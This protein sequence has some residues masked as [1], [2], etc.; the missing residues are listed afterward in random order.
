MINFQTSPDRY[1][2]WKL[3]VDGAVATLTMDV[4][5]DETLGEGYK[6][7]L[8]SYDLGVDIEL[9]DA[10][11]RIRFEHPEVR[12]VVVT[13]LKPRIFCAGAN[14]YMLGTSSHAFKVNF[15]KFTNETRCAME[16]DSQHSGRRYLAA[17]NGTASGGGYELAIAC[18]EI[19]LVDDGN[20]AVSLP[21]VPLLGVL[22]GTGGLTRLVD[23][24]KVRRDRADVFSTLA[25]GLKGKRAKEWGLID[26]TFPTS[27]FQ[28]SIE[29]RVAQIINAGKENETHGI[30]LHPLTVG[31]GLVPARA[32]EDAP[33]VDRAG[34]SPAPTDRD[35]KYVSLK[36]HR[37]KRYV[38]LTMRGPEADLPTSADEIQKLGDAFWPLQAYRE[39]DDALLHLRV[40]E[41]EIG[42]VCIRTEGSVDNVLALDRTLAAN[43]DHWLVREIILLMSRTLRRL[44]LTAKSFFAIV[45]PGSCFA[46]NLLELLVA[47]DRSYMLNNPDEPVAIAFSELNAGAFPMSNGLTRLQSRFLSEPQRVDEVLAQPGT[48][49]TE[50][51]EEAGLIT[52]A[53]DDLDWE[54]EIRVAIEERT[55]L[56][57]DALTGM[58]ASLRFAGPE[59]MDTKIYGRLTAWQNWIFQRPNAVGP[60]GALTNYG[61]PTQARFDFRRT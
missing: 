49:D 35:Y 5:E 10:I 54:D 37:E 11:Q 8:N 23:K 51:A 22:P 29:E 36:F 19:Y 4:H 26:G 1:R 2:H 45:E 42:L 18:D 59:T 21:E 20:S 46:G 28:E 44:D 27:K 30:K 17:L 15:C 56:S 16:D 40:N 57:P 50:A 55:S 7:K 31:A 38:D 6:L 43:R 12:A 47:S 41:P 13:S 58:E 3:A 33:H 48:L 61:K 39:L 14:I 25:E 53:P 60:N 52:F 32:S 9:A 34:T 24:R